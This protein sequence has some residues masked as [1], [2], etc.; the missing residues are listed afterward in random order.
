[1]ADPALHEAPSDTRH[2]SSSNGDPSLVPSARP[3]CA[4]LDTRLLAG[5]LTPN[6]QR[7]VNGVMSLL[8]RSSAGTPEVATAEA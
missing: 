3:H 2:I 6:A 7:D 4:A 8:A 1:M 5:V